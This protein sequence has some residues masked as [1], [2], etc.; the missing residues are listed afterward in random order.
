VETYSA[1]LVVDVAEAAS[2]AL[3]LLDEPVQAFGLALMMPVSMKASISGHQVSTVA[4]R[5]C[6][7]SIVVEAH[8]S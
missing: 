4:A 7:S 6:S 5:V 3:D 1:V 2:G 8:Q